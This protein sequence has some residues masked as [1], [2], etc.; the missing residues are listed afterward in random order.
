MSKGKF[1]DMAGQ[2][3]GKLTVLRR[4][5]N[6]GHHAAWECKCECGNTTVARGGSIRQGDTTSCGCVRIEGTVKA[7]QERHKRNRDAGLPHF[8]YKHGG[9]NSLEYSV[10][11][12]ILTSCYNTNHKNYKY[13]GAKGIT[14]DEGWKDSFEKFIQDVGHMPT[15]DAKALIRKDKKGNY[16]KHNVYWGTRNQARVSKAHDT[17]DRVHFRKT[18]NTFFVKYFCEVTQKD[19]TKAFSMKKYGDDALAF[20]LEFLE[21]T[22]QAQ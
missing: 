3:F 21:K 15:S 1:V 20:A 7:N 10:W 17:P 9:S 8:S 18:D 14:M 19:R 2:V 6:I 13:Y 11:R 4:A 12:G 22:K 16:H 5:E